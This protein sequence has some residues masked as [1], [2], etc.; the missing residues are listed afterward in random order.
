MKRKHLRFFPKGASECSCQIYTKLSQN[1]FLENK[2]YSLL[3]MIQYLHSMEYRIETG[4]VDTDG[5]ASQMKGVGRGAGSEDK[6]RV[7]FVP[8][9][10]C[11]APLG[12]R[13]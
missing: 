7:V 4:G 8:A 3:R 10:S 13:F 11:S 12:T 1:A 2:N 6:N 9:P 5:I